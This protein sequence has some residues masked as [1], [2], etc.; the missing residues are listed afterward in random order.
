MG[1]LYRGSV[2]EGGVI[3]RANTF[4]LLWMRAQTQDPVH[5]QMHSKLFP[6]EGWLYLLTQIGS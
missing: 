1:T 6:D 4:Q 5:S 2:G 3:E